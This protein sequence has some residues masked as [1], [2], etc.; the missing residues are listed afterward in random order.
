MP[1]RRH[2]D[3]APD[4]VRFGQGRVEHPGRAERTLQPV[5]DLEHPPFARHLLERGL[6]AAVRDVLAEHDD[7]GLARHLVLEGAV[8]R[9][10]HRVGLAGWHGWR[11]ERL[12]RRID[13]G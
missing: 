5:G 7:A 11:V 13:V 10:D 2:A 12:G 9:G 8:D 4:D 1:A 6:A 3:R